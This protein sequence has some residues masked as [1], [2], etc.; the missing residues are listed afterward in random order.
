[1]AGGPDSRHTLRT[2]VPFQIAAAVLLV[3]GLFAG[4]RWYVRS[5]SGSTR[6]KPTAALL[7]A[8]SDAGYVDAA[9]CSGC[10]REIWETYR[11]TG[12][13]RSLSRPRPDVLGGN[14]A[15]D[16][17]FYHAASDRHY[18]MYSKDG[19]YYERRHQIGFDGKETNVVEK[20]IHYV[21]G[22]GHHART[23]LHRTPEGKLFELPVAW[24]TEKGGYWAMNPGFDSGHH[25]DFRRQLMYECVF[26]HT[27]YPEIAS[28]SDGSGSEPLFPGR[29]PEGID[30]QRCHG[31]G[32]NH[33]Q[34][35]AAG[36]PEAI[37]ATIVNPR[38]LSGDRQLELCMQ[39]HLETTSARL[40]HTILRFDRGA[41]SYRPGEP[42]ADFVLHFDH[43][44][45]TGHDDKFE[46]AHQAYRLRKSA[47]F[48]KSDGRM[49]CTTCHDPHAAPRGEEAV[50]RY[51]SVCR[52]CHAPQ[53]DRLV[54]SQRHPGASDCLECH[55][56]KRRTEDV[57]HVV[58]TDHYI[59][60]RKPA[61]DLLAPLQERQETEETLYRGP[62]VLYYP[63]R[64][65]ATP[66]SELYL[67]VAQVKQFNN[68]PEGIPRL[69]AALEKHPTKTGEFYFEL[70]EACAHAGQE[71]ESIRFYE[72]AIRR[73]PDFRP[74]WLG[75]GRAL[76]KSGQHQRAVETLRKALEL[77]PEEAT[78]LNDLGLGLLRQGHTAEAVKVLERAAA[79]DPDHPEA[80]SNLGGALRETGDAAGAER[81]YRNTLRAQPDF[82]GAHRD[83]A[84]L[85]AA[86]NDFAQAE[87][88]YRKAIAQ[89]PKSALFH[90]DYGAA[91]A[92]VERF[93]QA[94][95]Q[96]EAA[97][98]LDPALAEAHT[99]LADM[100]AVRGNVVRAA[101]HY[102]RALT[103]QPEL[104]SAHLGLAAV[105]ETQ[106]RRAE[107]ISH[108]EKAA[109][110]S[111]AA[112]RQAAQEALRALQ[113]G[114]SAR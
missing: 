20:E 5:E 86:R 19:R 22:S 82:A 12:M 80:N 95:E 113:G 59:Q 81:A 73:R 100:L 32:R 31:P 45:G 66:E 63:P 44:P 24:Y 48:Q 1:M 78:I 85:L 108:L 111:D 38:R 92:G 33:L 84:D 101:E 36:K 77:G 13:G 70:A 43:A 79:V 25:S 103:L 3:A 60:R 74:A 30:C 71:K 53:L 29:L 28:G 7:I 23:Y 54:A 18:T 76:S 69:T 51:T 55:M 88:H 87:F 11:Q 47:C 52:G 68:L 35:A 65:P 91:L 61:R 62:V 17:T 9:A 98:R 114:R 112:A 110:S 72:E 34:A 4:Y 27:G 93:D 64:L 10:H 15:T 21:M 6:V 96:F 8:G 41:F 106:G 94:R 16:N 2:R 40:P 26:C 109:G 67:A 14:F 37:R 102:R 42:L 89:E 107:A 90:Q 83:L 97:V 56:P 46:I 39:C 75:L 57:A 49:T 105:L 104:G 99:G 58:M 50:K